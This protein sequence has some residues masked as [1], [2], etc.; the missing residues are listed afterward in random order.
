MELTEPSFN[1][2]LSI[3]I[4]T[5]YDV[6]R[7]FRE[8]WSFSLNPNNS[9]INLIFLILFNIECKTCVL[10]EAGMINNVFFLIMRDLLLLY[11]FLILHF[12]FV[13]L[14]RM[15]LSLFA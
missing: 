5:F 6:S 10:T 11:F 14:I 7:V 3:F 1:T 9:Q 8:G 2:D 4:V 12:I 13:S 15:F